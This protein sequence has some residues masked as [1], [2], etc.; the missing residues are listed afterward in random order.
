MKELS[1]KHSR[2]TVALYA[3][4]AS[5]PLFSVASL[6]AAEEVQRPG[7]IVLAA[8]ATSR[9]AALYLKKLTPTLD[10]AEQAINARN[11]GQANSYLGQA[12]RLVGQIQKKYSAAEIAAE[13]ALQAELDRYTGLQNS[14]NSANSATADASAQWV[15]KLKP[16][17]EGT[18]ALRVHSSNDAA[19]W[20]QWKSSY[21]QAK[22][23]WDEFQAAQLANKSPDLTSIEIELGRQLQ[24]YEQLYPAWEQKNA[25]AAQL[26]GDLLFSTSPMKP[27]SPQGAR[28][29][30]KSGDYIYG[31][32]RAKKSWKEIFGNQVNVLVEVQL[33]GQSLPTQS[34]LLKAPELQNSKE[35]AL[36]IAPA[37]E[38]MSA[39]SDPRLEYGTS[40]AGMRQGPQELS[41]QL[42]QLAPGKHTL[43]FTVRYY[44]KVYAQGGFEIEGQNFARYGELNKS[45]QAAAASAVTLPAAQ[46]R[47]PVMEQEMR[48]LLAAAGWQAI[49][50]LNIVDKEWWTDRVSG[51]NSG[52][53]SRHMDA[54]VLAKDAT[55][56]FYRKVRFQED[57]LLT[58]G[59]GPL[60]IVHTGERF[61]VPAA[62]IDK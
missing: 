42:A 46:Q 53:S 26:Q 28:S 12:E 34:I 9:G 6:H 61:A 29:S 60:H 19:Q 8:N 31:L 32:I 45:Y 33:D 44:G 39:Y 27:Q 21:A 25:A 16:Y 15:S 38:K 59:F 48:K 40:K 22:P 54:A 2:F 17:T 35:L 50:R 30:F 37:P 62:N 47:N 23:L 5:L 11:M 51:G 18:T 24:K 20:G 49:H 56:H 14:V 7:V 13:P 1:M 4:V 41:A 55:G 10:K 52:V 3:T 57:K 36:E 43:L 58:G